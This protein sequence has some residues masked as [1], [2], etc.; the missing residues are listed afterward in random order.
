MT[1]QP[2]G[3][4]GAFLTQDYYTRGTDAQQQLALPQSDPPDARYVLVI[5]DY[6]LRSQ[7][8][9]PRSVGYTNDPLRS[10][11]GTEYISRFLIPAKYIKFVDPIV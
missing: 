11:G 2:D 5:D 7:L 3:N 10:G 9:G 1:L 6:E 4:Y 8:D